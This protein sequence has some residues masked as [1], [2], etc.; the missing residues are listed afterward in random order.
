MRQITVRQESWP[1]RGVF[2]IARG[3][4]TEVTVIVVEIREG[5]ALGRGECRPY[6]RYGETAEGVIGAIE[7]LI[8]RLAAGLDRDE[9]AHHLAPGAARNAIDC[10]LWDLAAKRNHQ[11]VWMLAGLPAPQPLTTAFTL[12]V[13]TPANLAQTARIEAWRPFLKIKLDGNRDLERLIAVRTH[14][15]R[16]RL[17]VDINEAWSRA[18]YETIVPELARLGVDLLEQPFAAGNDHWL[19]ALPRPVPVCADESCH[20]GE[21]LAGLKGRYD[22]VNIKLD[23]AGGL[24]E[25][26]RMKTL[27]E[28]LGF[29]VMVGCMVATS[30]AMAPAFFVA[31]GA[32]YTDLDGPLL[33]AKDRTPGLRFEGSRILPPDHELWG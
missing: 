20:D 23:K 31:Q 2:R 29:S 17:I 13:D 14:A 10:A 18:D 1:V 33:L 26:L 15:P 9:L 19:A 27:A 3:S 11:P 30:L 16:S 6:G 8:P 28:E 4:H 24:T 32:A 5:S 22:A 25:A 7:A 21:D 12:S